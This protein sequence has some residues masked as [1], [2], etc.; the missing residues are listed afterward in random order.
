MTTKLSQQHVRIT[1]KRKELKSR[2]TRARICAPGVV[3][4]DHVGDS[5]PSAM[6]GVQQE[7]HD[8][9]GCTKIVALLRNLVSLAGH[10][11]P[12]RNLRCALS[13][14]Q[15][16][17]YTASHICERRKDKGGKKKG[18]RERHTVRS[19]I[20]CALASNGGALDGEGEQGK[21][22]DCSISADTAVFVLIFCCNWGKI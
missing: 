12:R 18:K 1:A 21:V 15:T 19:I 4:K 14:S 20:F 3:L 7:A 16:P 9:A 6:F 2:K 17:T 22:Y 13:L 10:S 11:S 8:G 5:L